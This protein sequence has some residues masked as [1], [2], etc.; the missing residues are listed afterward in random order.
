MAGDVAIYPAAE[1]Q[2]TLSRRK[3]LA[4]APLAAA[5]AVALYSAGIA[6]HELSV[7]TRSL[8]IKD[9]PP[10]FEGYRVVQISDIHFDE[11][12]EPFFIRRVI[13]NVN[14]LKPDLVLLTG[15]FI[16]FAP[17]P[18]RF[19]EHALH[20][21]TE[22]LEEIACPQTFA[23]MGNHD[24]FLGAP[25][26]IPVFKA[27]NI[28]LLVNRHVPIER[29]GQRLWLCATHDPVTHVPDL[30][31]TIPQ[32]PDGP[33]LLMCH[34]P[35]YADELLAH[36]RGRLVDVMFAGHTHG[37]QVRI[38]LLPPLHLPEGGRKYVEGAFQLGRLQ[39]YVNRGIGAVGLPFRLN[40]PPEITVFTLKKAFTQS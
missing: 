21:C 13:R 39:L 24:S 38:P 25:E 14:S 31:A 12:T 9:L 5:G 7:V 20:H 16:S 1:Q 34:G 11:Y 6:R 36:P 3:F 35:D 18:R 27:V 30:D 4:R 29:N 22:M 37:G 32:N 15:D 2:K 26:M 8:S 10:A 19:A 40:C 33:V 23:A 17:L 28:P